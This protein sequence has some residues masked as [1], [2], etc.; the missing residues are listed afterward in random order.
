MLHDYLI[1]DSHC[2]D[3]TNVYKSK[4]LQNTYTT[5]L[6][7]CN[8]FQLPYKVGSFLMNVYIVRPYF[9]VLFLLYKSIFI[10]LHFSVFVLGCIGY[11]LKDV[12][13]TN[14]FVQ[15]IH[16]CISLL[17]TAVPVVR[18]LITVPKAKVK[19]TLE[20]RKFS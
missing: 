5:A 3:Y 9:P 19:K 20:I 18:V 7:L 1:G 2:C 8:H 16:T 13:L 4:C 10:F 6:T 11:T 15:N 17:N 12:Y 14:F